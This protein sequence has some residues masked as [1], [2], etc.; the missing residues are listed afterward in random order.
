MGGLVNQLVRVAPTL[1]RAI[2][3]ICQYH[4]Q[5]IS[6]GHYECFRVY[7]EATYLVLELTPEPAA[8]RPYP[9]ASH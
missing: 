5:V 4:K 9:F 7:Q 3:H 1:R 8:Y 2:E 6:T